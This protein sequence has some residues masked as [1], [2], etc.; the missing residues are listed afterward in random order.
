[1]VVV[2]VATGSIC[3]RTALGTRRFARSGHGAAARAD[4]LSD[5]CAG[6][7]A[8]ASADHG[9]GISTNG[10]TYCGTGGSAYRAPHHCP[11]LSFALS[12]HGATDGTTDGTT[13][14]GAVF[15]ADGLA[16][17]RAGGRAQTAADRRFQVTCLRDA[18]QKGHR[19]RCQNPPRSNA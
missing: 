17:C 18:R 12:A 6:C 7:A 15:L 19:Q 2:I 11:G 16:D 8:D 4:A 10:F 5:N 1:M 9:T 14:H 13:D 3:V